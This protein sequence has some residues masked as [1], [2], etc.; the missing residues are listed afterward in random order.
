MLAAMPEG[1]HSRPLL[2]TG[3]NGHLGRRILFR[4]AGIRPVRAVV[5][6]ERAADTLRSLPEAARP[7]I[8]ILSY[9]DEAALCE[10]ASGCDAGVHLVGIVKEGRTAS[11]RSAHEDTCR[12][13]ARA[14]SRAGLRRIVY[15]S[16]L[17]S[18]PG[19]ANPCLA[20]KG[21]AESILM[22]G[23]TPVTVLRVPMVI[24]EGDVAS[25]ALAGQARAPLLF[26]VDGGRTWQQPIDAAD[27][28]EAVVHALER[29]GT[30]DESF[31]LAGPE[32]LRHRDLIER[33]A[34]LYGRQPRIVPVPL[35]LARLA[36]AVLARTSAD[37]P[38]TPAMLD[39]LQHDDRVD[40]TPA[41][42]ALGLSLTPLD[43]T[44]ARCVGPDARE[45][46]SMETP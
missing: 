41:C 46:P 17:G 14:A 3:A 30:D 6:S 44:L 27:V 1:P 40:P 32:P 37:P 26:L 31:D 25:R 7:E 38:I 34:A 13:L 42:E 18:R 8:R 19:A 33:A 2:V 36:A 23:P 15:L 29:G 10:A 11:Y 28:V 21:R 5:R 45:T 12:V 20:S 22:E 43:Q 4:M 39:V 9:T 24:G 35:G 16:I